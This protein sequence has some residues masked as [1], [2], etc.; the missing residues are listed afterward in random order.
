MKCDGKKLY[1]KDPFFYCECDEHISEDYVCED[2]GTENVSKI[3][4]I[5]EHEWNKDECS[6]CHNLQPMHNESDA[7]KFDFT[8]LG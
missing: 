5:S 4:K 8:G 6:H 7:K 1:L 3:C 2:C